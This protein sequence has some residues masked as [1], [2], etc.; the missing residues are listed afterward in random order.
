[1][2]RSDRAATLR[3]L[4]QYR[5]L[6]LMGRASLP[7]GVARRLLGPDCAFHLYFRHAGHEREATVET[8]HMRP[9]RRRAR[10]PSR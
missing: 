3:I 10:R 6:V 4:R 2:L 7:L 1:V 9:A 8:R 5:R